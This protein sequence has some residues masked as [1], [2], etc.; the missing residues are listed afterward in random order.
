MQLHPTLKPFLE[1]ISF[2]SRYRTLQH[3]FPLGTETFEKYSN[4]E[5]LKIL[6]SLGYRF[7]FYR[8]ENFFGMKESIENCSFTFNISCKYGVV[9]FIW[10]LLINDRRLMLGGPWGLIG[11]LMLNEKC[12]I[13]NP[14]FKNYEDLR[15]ILRDG[16]QIYE[17]FKR[18][19]LADPEALL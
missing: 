1:R 14:A 18:E 7:K 5:V 13:K 12:N 10:D 4:D 2:L 6:E 9:E 3:R 19:V 16:L 17:D 8:K 15:E 11:D